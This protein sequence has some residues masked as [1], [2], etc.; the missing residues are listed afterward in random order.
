MLLTSKT[1]CV[2]THFRSL[3]MITSSLFVANKM[4][5]FKKS[6]NL[7]TLISIFVTTKK[8]ADRQNQLLTAFIWKTNKLNF[9]VFTNFDRQKRIFDFSEPFLFSLK[10]EHFHLESFH[11]ETSMEAVSKYIELVQNISMK[12]NQI[13]FPLYFLRHSVNLFKKMWNDSTRFLFTIY[14]IV[15]LLFLWQT[16]SL[17]FDKV[18]SVEN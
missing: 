14:L 4:W 8:V 5:S 3:M 17:Q 15:N 2:V 18:N 13:T 12:H 10:I 7:K 9:K 11:C 16:V 1:L 6:F